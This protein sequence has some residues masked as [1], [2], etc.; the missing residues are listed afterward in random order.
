M[1][2]QF[3]KIKS[4]NNLHFFDFE[5]HPLHQLLAEFFSHQSAQSNYGFIIR[6]KSIQTKISMTY[7]IKVY[8]TLNRQLLE[9]REGSSFWND[10]PCQL[11]NSY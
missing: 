6:T 1:Q 8:S 10:A 4:K 5:E 3:C 7:F 9:I 2:Y 11:V